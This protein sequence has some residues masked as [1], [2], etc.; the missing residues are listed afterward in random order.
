MKTWC[1]RGLK[2]QFGLGLPRGCEIHPRYFHLFNLFGHLYIFCFRTNSV[3]FHRNKLYNDQE[4]TNKTLNNLGYI[5]HLLTHMGILQRIYDTIGAFRRK[6]VR[7]DGRIRIE[8]CATFGKIVRQFPQ[9]HRQIN[10]WRSLFTHFYI[11]R[12]LL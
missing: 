8:S 2:L 12:N 10:P 4:R 9:S 1:G 7:Q 3:K 11:S 5:I 6:T